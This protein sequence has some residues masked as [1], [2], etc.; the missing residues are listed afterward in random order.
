MTQYARPDSLVSNAGAWIVSPLWDL[1]DET[2]PADADYIETPNNT[3]TKLCEVGL[4]NVTDPVSDANHIISWRAQRSGTGTKVV[5]T[6]IYLYEGATLRATTGQ[7]TEGAAFALHT[8]TLTAGEAASI[9][10]YTDLRFRIE[11]V[12]T[13]T[14]A[15]VGRVSWAELAV[16]DAGGGSASASASESASI[17]PSIS[18]SASES[19]SISPSIS[20]SASGSASASISASASESASISPSASESVSE[21]ASP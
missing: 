21:S 4:S 12:L 20:G 3:G 2:P 19:A 13:G 10:D 5:Q 9:T 15:R 1:I 7:Y 18:A 8:Y 6:R 17:S 14:G 11:G 16:P